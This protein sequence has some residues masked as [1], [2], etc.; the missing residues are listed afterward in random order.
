MGG[1]TEWRVPLLLRENG[2]A[3]QTERVYDCP[4][5]S[6]YRA[7][8]TEARRTRMK[9]DNTWTRP[10]YRAVKALVRLCYPKMRV[11]G[12]EHLPQEP[13]LIVGNH[14]QMNGP[15]ACEL[16]FPGLRYTWCAGQMMYLSISWR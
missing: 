6:G 7:L 8:S 16:Y 5:G 2:F 13:A 4:G 15:I 1:R 3:F 14:T 11:E 12:T 9:K 10:V